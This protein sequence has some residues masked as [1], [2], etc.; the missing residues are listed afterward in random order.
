MEVFLSYFPDGRKTR[1]SLGLG[2]FSFNAEF[3]EMERTFAM[4]ICT[5]APQSEG[6]VV[7]YSSLF[8]VTVGRM[9]VLMSVG[10]L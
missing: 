8:W 10:E 3:L 1:L 7:C 2:D 9:K 5:H 4:E 6:W